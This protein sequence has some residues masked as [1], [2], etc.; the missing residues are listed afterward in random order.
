MR[1]PLT[2]DHFNGL[3]KSLEEAKAFARGEAVEGLRVHAERAIDIAA[4]RRGAGLSQTDFARHIGV[5]VATL[6][7]WEQGRRRPEGPARILIA[8]LERDPQIVA[9]TLAKAA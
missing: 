4:V 8:L 1:G 6:R 7:N 3:M 9:R 2:S 5:S